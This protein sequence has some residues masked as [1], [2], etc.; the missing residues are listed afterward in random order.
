MA[1]FPSG[2]MS[3]VVDLFVRELW[4]PIKKQFGYCLKPESKVRK[5]A[6][7]ADDLKENIDLVKEKIKLGELEGK[8][9]RVQATRW[10]DDSAKLVEDESYRIKNT[11]DGRST[12]IF[13]CSW[14]CFFNYRISS[15]ATKKKADA[16]EF[17]ESTPKNDS[18][19][20]LLPPVGRE[21]PLPPNI[22]GQNRYMKEIV[23]CIK[24]GT[25]SFI[26][27]CGMGGAGKTTL[28]KQLNNIF[29][30]AAETH[31]FDYIIY[32]EVGQQQDLDTVRQNVASQLGLVIGKDESTTFRSSSLY[33]FLKERKFLLLIDDLW[34]TL[35]LVQIGIP[36]GGRLIGPQNRQMIVIT[37]RL[38]HLCHRIQVHGQLIML[39]RLEF[40]EAWNLFDANAGCNRVTNSSAQIRVYAKSIVNMCGGLPL[41]LKIV[42]QAMASKE[43]EHEWKH[44]MILLRRS[45]FHKVPDA[46]SNLFSLLYISY[47]NLPDERTKH[48]FLFFVLA[49]YD[50]YS[51]VP[52]AINLW[53]GHGFLDEDDDI[54]NNYLRGHSVVGC[55]K[56]ACLLEEHPRG[57]NYVRMHDIIR[58]LTL[59]IVQMQ[60]GDRHNNKWQVRLCGEPMEPEEWST[61]QRISLTGM[62]PINIPDSCS[63]ICLLTLSVPRSK[64]IGSV[65]TGFFRTA[66]SLTYLDLSQTNIQEL[67]SDV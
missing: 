9:P 39:Q 7:A 12:H 55:L 36:Q 8:K 21:L 35:D 44:A 28:L 10:I 48:C 52:Y 34:Q 18:I 4:K 6:K 30:C 53:I 59:W 16:D 22:M 31:E 47:E 2:I 17:K 62:N 49:G 57:E 46:E 54:R 1:P 40:V 5:L 56:R 37:T 25:T 13:G 63:C 41:A 32:V 61:A 24:Q 45:Q 66:P 20:S 26:G 42:G 43:S 3:P 23:A 60:Q 38:Q 14:N 19:F 58:G 51:Y 27:I 64:I 15:A 33:N 67:P 29:S 65:P 50:H 11:Y